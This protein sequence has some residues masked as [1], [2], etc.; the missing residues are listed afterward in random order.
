MTFRSWS[1][2]VKKQHEELLKQYRQQQ[3]KET[4]QTKINFFTQVAHEIRTPLSLIKMPLESIIQSGDGNE[5]TRKY[6][7]TMI[8]T[9]TFYST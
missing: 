1:K 7:T 4:Y 5:E 2:R 8:K 6:L 3:E 9:R